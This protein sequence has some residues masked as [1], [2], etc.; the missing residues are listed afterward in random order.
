M[1]KPPLVAQA[2]AA[3]IAMAPAMPAAAQEAARPAPGPLTI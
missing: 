2:A 1:S 3:L